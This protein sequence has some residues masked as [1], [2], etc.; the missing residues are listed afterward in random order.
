M[1]GEEGWMEGGSEGGWGLMG[2]DDL[3]TL[4]PA[5]PSVSP[6]PQAAPSASAGAQAA[7]ES[8]VVTAAADAQGLTT[9]FDAAAVTVA[10]AAA[11][12]AAAACFSSTPATFACCGGPGAGPGSGGAVVSGA[13]AH[14]Q[15]RGPPQLRQ[16]RS[17]QTPLSMLAAA[18]PLPLEAAAAAAIAASPSAPLACGAVLAAVKLLVLC[19]FLQLHVE[20]GINSSAFYEP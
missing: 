13:F 19:I 6:I 11:A 17:S 7:P 15:A 9:F 4:A 8:V 5:S 2:P 14:A 16:A 3:V 1:D 20:H 18:Q 10:A 12:A